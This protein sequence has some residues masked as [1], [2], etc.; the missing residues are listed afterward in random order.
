MLLV[1][2]KSFIK[3]LIRYRFRTR[4]DGPKYIALTFDDGPD[5]SVTP[6]L[7]GYLA[8]AGVHATFF[9]VGN[10]VQANPDIARAILAGGHDIGNHSLTHRPDYYDAYSSAWNPPDKNGYMA[11]LIA[12]QNIIK[13]ETGATPLF[14]RPPYLCEN[15][16]LLQAAESLGHPIIYSIDFRDYIAGLSPRIIY[17][18]TVG[19]V[20][21][22]DILLFH[23]QGPNAENAISAIPKIL[24][25]LINHEGFT[26]L[27]LSEMLARRNELHL[28]P[29]RIYRDFT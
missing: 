19:V 24:K 25:N 8:D 20:K 2:G 23:D 26:V 18:R 16:N 3:Y 13:A 14:F 22:W 5:R 15:E 9:L 11:E 10:H 6:R 1:T 12:A 27:S 28:E 4:S 21:P 7:L 17:W 29:G